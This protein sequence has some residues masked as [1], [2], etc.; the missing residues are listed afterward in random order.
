MYRKITEEEHIMSRT[1]KKRTAEFRA[2]Q[3]KSLEEKRGS[4]ITEMDSIIDGAKAE[5]RAFTKEESDRMDAITAEIESLNG[6][7]SAERRAASL[8]AKIEADKGAEKPDAPVQAQQEQ[9]A[10]AVKPTE[11]ETRAFENYIKAQIGAPVSEIRA[12]SN[13]TM[14]D[15]GAVIPTSISSMIISKVKEIC[16][17]LSGATMFAVKGTLKVPVW[18]AKSDGSNITVGFHKEF[19]ELTASAG[20][21]VS[22]DLTGYLAGVLTRIGKSLITNSEIDI[23]G[24]VTDEM[25]KEITYF[26]EKILLAKETVVDKEKNSVV[27][28]ALSTNTT[29]TAANKNGVTVDDLIALQS[30]IPAVYQANSCWTMNNATFLSIKK[31]KDSTGQYMLMQNTGN[32]SG[33]FP[34]MLLGKPVYISENMPVAAAGNRSVLY[35]DYSGLGV[36]MRQQIEMQVLNE[37]YATQHAVGIVGWFEVDCNVI[38]H[39]KLAALVH[40]GEV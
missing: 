36:N 33:A 5:T 11:A 38:N 18:G 8:K 10:E 32:I 2:E 39:Q 35:G 3:V 29:V 21:F 20:N 12:D 28:G 19:D 13:L 31:L 14:G 27:K 7:I 24:F 16:P 6:T 40:E 34:Y 26:L 15:N 17:I 23:L 4:L 37:K 25:A 1:M 30:A 22:V 9:R